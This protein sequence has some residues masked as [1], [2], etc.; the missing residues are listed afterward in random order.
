MSW[1][2][3]LF[4]FISLIILSCE[5]DESIEIKFITTDFIISEMGPDM[6]FTITTP[7]Y[8]NYI[9]SS[10]S[11]ILL[12]EG[13]KFHP[14]IVEENEMNNLAQNL[15]DTFIFHWEVSTSMYPYPEDE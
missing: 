8:E 3:I 2:L 4:V 9:F 5:V 15:S 6:R 13:Y 12:S 11:S 1:K 10:D 7:E 14:Y